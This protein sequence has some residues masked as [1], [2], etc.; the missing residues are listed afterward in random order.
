MTY[1]K[2]VDELSVGDV[3]VLVLVEV[4]EDDAELLSCEEDAQLGHE[5]LEFELLKDSVLVAIEAL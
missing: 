1:L 4:V 2:D 3:A 5:L